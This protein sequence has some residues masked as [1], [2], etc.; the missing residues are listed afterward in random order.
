MK[1][2]RKVLL[3]AATIL[4]WDMVGTFTGDLGK[5]ARGQLEELDRFINSISSLQSMSFASL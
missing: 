1:E 3:E 4:S 5:V 2:M